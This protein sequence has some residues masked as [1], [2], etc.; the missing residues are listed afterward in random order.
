MDKAYDKTKAG[1][2]CVPQDSEADR[3]GHRQNQGAE[4]GYH[5]TVQGTKTGYHK[6]VDATKTGADKVG[7]TL[8]NKHQDPEDFA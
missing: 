3:K 4:I 2:D 6:T 7:D 5:K 1:L 8:T